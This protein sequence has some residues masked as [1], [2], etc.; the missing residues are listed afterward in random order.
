[1]SLTKL[2]NIGQLVTYNSKLDEMEVKNSIEIII[3]DE[4]VIEIG[5]NLFNCDIN[6]DC[7]N[8]LVT[9]GFVDP[10]THPIFFNDRQEEFS[11]RLSGVSYEQISKTGG[12]IL[13]SVS[14]FR[15]A[16]IKQIKSKVKK[17]MD[18][19]LNLGTTTV[20]CKS[21]YGLDVESELKSLKVIDEV[22]KEHE[23]EMV[24]TFM[25]AHAFPLEYKD[26]NDGYVNLICSKMIPAIAEQ[27]IAV[28]N[29]VFCE[30][31]YFD[32]EQSLRILEAGKK[33]GL[34]P[35]LHADEFRD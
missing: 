14:D 23:I 13:S 7:N 5:N 16:T 19:F 20:E 8:M 17:R 22:N 4:T 2:S 15:K 27:G 9:P 33:Y 11:L 18:N 24:T 21:G 12:G 10:H 3:E 6:I 25:G 26:D 28:F 35:R 34:Q 31:G 29:D 1:M 32:L 30:D